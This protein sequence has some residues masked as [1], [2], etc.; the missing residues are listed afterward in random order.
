MTGI[1]TPNPHMSLCV[2]IIE[3]LYSVTLVYVGG[4]DGCGDHLLELVFGALVL[5]IGLTELEEGEPER[6]K[7]SCKVCQ[8]G[9]G[10]HLTILCCVYSVFTLCWIIY[11]RVLHS[12]HHSHAVS[13]SWQPVTRKSYK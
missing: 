9:G 12:S 7:R 5:L 2:Y 3:Y 6:L 11:W 8:Y 4:G 1:H 13:T 10:V